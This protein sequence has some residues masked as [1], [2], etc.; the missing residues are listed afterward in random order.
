MG[1]LLLSFWLVGGEQSPESPFS[2]PHVDLYVMW[3]SSG[4]GSSNGD[5]FGFF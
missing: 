2:D 1:L 3:D 5:N 4:N